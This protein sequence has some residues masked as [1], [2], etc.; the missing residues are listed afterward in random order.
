MLFYYPWFIVYLSCSGSEF[1][2]TN[3]LNLVCTLNAQPPQVKIL[4]FI[5]NIHQRKKCLYLYYKSHRNKIVWKGIWRQITG[6]QIRE[7]RTLKKNIRSFKAKAHWGYILLQTGTVFHNIHGHL[8]KKQFFLF[9][10]LLPCL[11]SAII[12]CFSKILKLWYIPHAHM[13]YITIKLKV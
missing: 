6:Q 7:K 1:S 4:G 2:I 3:M 13:Y 10:F 11:A 12:L 9:P 5:D 8:F